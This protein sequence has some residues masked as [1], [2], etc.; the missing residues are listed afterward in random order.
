MKKQ[1]KFI[2]GFMILLIIIIGVLLF[3]NRG[4]A[5]EGQGAEQ[6]RTFTVKVDGNEVVT[7]TLDALKEMESETFPAVIRSSGKKPEEVTYTGVEIGLLLETAG[8]DLKDKKQLTFTA[9]DGY[10]VTAGVKEL[11]ETGNFYLAYGLNGEDLKTKSEEGNGP[12]QLI[13]RKDPFSQR[14]CK[15]LKEVDIQ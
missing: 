13:I 10:V 4:S 3:F 15:Y 11:A 8:I 12:Y 6:D 7:F 14:W 2:I 1:T 9:L 5:L